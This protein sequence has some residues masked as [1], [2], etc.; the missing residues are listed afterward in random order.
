MIDCGTNL[1]VSGSALWHSGPQKE[2]SQV[3]D[4]MANM[5]NLVAPPPLIEHALTPVQAEAERLCPGVTL[6]V[7]GPGTGKTITL[8][9]AVVSR[10]ESGIPLAELAVLASSRQAAQALR[11]EVVGRLHHAQPRPVFTTV[12]GLALGLLRELQPEAD[13][14]WT[15]LRGPQQEERIRDLLAGSAQVW[16]E[17]VRGALGTTGFARQ[18]RE[19]LARARQR[20]L[21]EHDL[22]RMAEERG[23]PVLAAVAGF[24]HEYLQ[25]GDLECTLDYAELVYRAR[26][27]LRDD[28][29]AASVVGRFRSVMVDDAH[30]LD[31]AQIAFL[32]D[33]ARLGI[34]VLA[35]ADPS[36]VVS[37]FRGA[38]THAVGALL[39]VAPSRLVRLE[40]THRHAGCVQA[41]LVSLRSRLGQHPLMPP[42]LADSQATGSVEVTI[43]DSFA[44]EV[45]QVAE[46][47]R[48][49]A[50]EGEDWADMAVITRAGRAQLTPYARALSR[51]GIPVEVAADELVVAEDEVAAALLAGLALAAA[52]ESADE[53][54]TD[55][56]LSSPLGGLDALDLRRARRAAGEMP[57]LQWARALDATEEWEAAPALARAIDAAAQLLTDGGTVAEAL[58]G[59][60]TA[61]HLPA[62]LKE[63]ALAGE[64]AA[65]RHLDAVVE[66]FERAGKAPI[67]TGRSGAHTFIRALEGEEIP[68]DTGRES[69]LVGRGVQLTTA[70]R[71]KGREWERVFVVGVQEGRWPR[72]TPG[73][74]LLDPGR[75]LDDAPLRVSEHVQQE[76]RLFTLA[77]ARA[78]SHLHVSAVE[79]SDDTPSRFVHELAVEPRIVQGMPQRPLTSAALVGELRRAIIDEQS[80]AVLRRG[81]ARRLA[82]LS[83]RGVTAAD[84][85]HWWGVREAQPPAGHA[86]R[87]VLSGSAITDILACPRHYFL[88]RRAG[89]DIDHGFA[90]RFGTL[91]HQL[92]Q[93]AQAEQLSADA[94]RDRLAHRWDELEFAAPWQSV[95][96]RQ[97]A[98]QIVERLA[99]W[100]E[101]HRD[102][103]L[104]EEYP[105]EVDLEVGGRPVRLVGTVDRLDMIHTA[106]GPQLRVVDFKTQRKAPTRAELAEHVQLGLYQLVAAQGAFDRIAPGVS[107][108]APPALLLLR[109]DAAGLPKLCE[110]STLSVAP[111]LEGEPLVVGPTWIHDRIAAAAE[112]IASG[113]YAARKGRACDHCSFRASC[114]TQ[115]EEIA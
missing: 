4:S 19:L 54:D 84:P 100:L 91:L 70:H 9:E 44:T 26:L 79:N 105:F 66:L 31:P 20:S 28:A 33:L 11:R 93:E 94:M 32:A 40:R 108:V 58:W 55:A 72:A 97:S 87:I 56:L 17:S 99:S 83:E 78:R 96:E 50:A 39:E 18:L 98:E 88:S 86:G 48:R 14:P 77:C 106:Q 69:T 25:V 3:C 92:A 114:P 16:P 36:Q 57:L 115:V 5:W 34:P 75:L 43:H 111:E 76:R 42:L 21:D 13:A 113:H 109:L 64:R 62:R 2:L 102:T 65:H 24:L 95:A 10:V 23:D 101:A 80:P 7:G 73:G 30:D 27:L 45:G 12:H 103:L 85:A 90:A 53:P 46:G 81:A 1:S 41:S 37:A 29:P 74:L 38:D 61:S 6:A 112:V 63:A 15:L 89:A 47:L 22:R 110:Q 35:F 8:V 82:A 68:A 104:A 67:L 52:P 51:V 59:I 71:A 107:A 60:W 49:A